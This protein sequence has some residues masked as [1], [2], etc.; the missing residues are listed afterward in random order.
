MSEI[1]KVSDVIAFQKPQ[2]SIFSTLLTRRL[3]RVLTFYMLKFF[4]RATPNHVS[5]LSFV[6]GVI[7]CGLFLMP[8]YWWRV[9]GV[10]LLQLG[11]AFDCSDGEIARIKNLSSKFG[12]WLDSVFDRFKEF[13]M[14]GSMTIFW[15]LY[16]NENPWVLVVGF[17]AIIGLQL[18]SYL[19]EAKKSSW[20]ST[21][22]A[23]LF[24][25]KN[26]YIGTVDVTIYLVSLAVLVNMEII[27]LW[28]FLLVS[29]PLILK[30]LRSA[31]RLGKQA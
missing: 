26:I 5:F 20:P 24:I 30:Q 13:L 17:S 21:R 27:A 31:Y 9:L 29:I 28:I 3:S 18:V 15:F 6:L 4:P 22:T 2:D 1:K 25:T 7:A 23:E 11:F 14:L 16:K 12:A 8:N 10:A 19:R